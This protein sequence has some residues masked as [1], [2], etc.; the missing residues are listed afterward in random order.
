MNASSVSIKRTSGPR[1]RSGFTLIELLVVIAII[2]ILAAMLLPAL[3]K[4]KAKAQGIQCMSNLKQLGVAWI[5]YSSDSNSKLAPNGDEGAQGAS[6][7]DPL[8]QGADLQWCP[9][10]V[11]T[12]APATWQTNNAFLMAGCIYPYLKNVAVY[13]CPADA[14]TV[15]VYGQQEL[16]NRSMSM[17][18]WLNPI[19]LWNSSANGRAF[20]KDSDLGVLGAAN[21]W[22]VMDENPY[23]INDAYM[24]EY[25]PPGLTGGANLNWVD[26]PAT[27]HNGANGMA[28]CDGHAQIRKWTDPVVLNMRTEDPSSLPAT[29]GNND[30]AWLQNVTTKHE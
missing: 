14:S 2:A 29:A 13:H 8:Y 19:N 15:L 27:Y 23:S 7:T 20:R 5:M 6:A 17:N 18:C 3:S 4:A 26:Y 9:G 30:L 24:A 28:F 1:C 25:P 10:R 22:L 11:D 16:K 21:V 12:G